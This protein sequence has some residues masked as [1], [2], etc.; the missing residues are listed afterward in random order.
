ARDGTMCRPGTTVGSCPARA[1]Q[2]GKRGMAKSLRPT[3]QERAERRRA[4]RERLSHAAEQLLA[5]DGWTRWVL[6]RS[7][8]PGYS[9]SNC[10]L[11]AAQCHER[12]IV[13]RQVRGMHA[14]C[15]LGRR[16][17][18]GERALRI[19]APVTITERDADGLQTGRRVFF[20]TAYVFEL[21]Q[22]E[23]LP[24]GESGVAG[25]REGQPLSGNSHARLL[26]PLRALAQSQGYAVTFTAIGGPSCG[27]CDTER[28]LIAIDTRAP[29]NAQV[30]ALVHE[31]VHALGIDYDRHPRAR[32]EVIADTVAFVVCTGVGLS[33][34]AES[35]PYLAGW[36]KDGALAAVTDF[37]R[38]ID[39]LARRIEA[40]VLAPV[41]SD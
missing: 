12:G 17:R 11:L 14:W 25:S 27:W 10:M 22:T 20:R 29:A 5:H 34:D 24:G 38:T 33:L 36:G 1:P 3:E 35:V 39:A 28:R 2:S 37:A 18:K 16:V 4:D 30:R 13:P 15:K 32:A 23:P 6:A 26:V 7:T 21:S 40:V 19:S 31:C 9:A 8:L 41:V